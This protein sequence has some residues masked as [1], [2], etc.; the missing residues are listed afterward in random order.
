MHG[1]KNIPHSPV[2]I[3]FG[4]KVRYLI[5]T[6]RARGKY[7]V[8]ITIDT[9][10]LDD[11]KGSKRDFRNNDVPIEKDFTHGSSVG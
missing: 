1:I 10:L 11:V 3:L 2:I 8:I 6:F 9:D 5:D 7:S 4:H